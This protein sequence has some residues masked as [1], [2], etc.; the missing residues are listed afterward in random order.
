LAKDNWRRAAINKYVLSQKNDLV[1]PIASGFTLIELMVTL[2]V[3]AILLTLAIPSFTGMIDKNRL[4]SAAEAL[5]AD[6]QFARAEAIKR[7]KK[8]RVSFFS[9]GSTWC[10]GL[11]ENIKCDCQQTDV[12]EKDFCEIDG[13][14]KSISSTEFTDIVIA[15]SW[16][17]N[18][19]SFSFTPLRGTVNGGNVEFQ[20]AEK[21]V[22][23]VVIDRLGSVRLCSP[24]GEGKVNGYPVC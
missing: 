22:V 15:N 12:D 5:Y 14:R 24:S 8:I 18:S 7:N 11:K 2:A 23:K 4:K 13:I 10:Y 20:S 1:R 19:N 9:N 3:A 6:L 17:N 21:K 16:T